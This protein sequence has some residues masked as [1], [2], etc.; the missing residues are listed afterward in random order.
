M[1]D[2][3]TRLREIVGPNVSKFAGMV[4]EHRQTIDNYLV[5]RMPRAAFLK[6]LAEKKDININWLLT[7]KGPKELSATA[8]REAKVRY[9]AEAAIN[10]ITKDEYKKLLRD[11]RSAEALILM[12][13]ISEAVA[14]DDPLGI[15]EKDI[16]SFVIISQKWVKQEH[17]YRCLRVRGNSMHPI[18]SDGFIIAIDLT[19]NDPLRLES[20]VV[21]ARYQDSVIIKYLLLTERD[22]IL[23]PHNM[24]EYKPIAIPRTAPNP[25]IGKVAWWW[26]KQKEGT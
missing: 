7:G 4:G 5:G 26:G 23:T 3:K 10:I 18:I 11:Q 16:E 20:Q 15:K 6:K 25:I 2:V 24:T 13:L 19:E 14:V 22:Y 17:T 9:G 8:V 1:S 21:A 12:P